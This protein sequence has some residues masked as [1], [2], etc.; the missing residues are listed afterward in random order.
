MLERVGSYY[1]ILPTY[2]QAKKIIWE[3]M[4]ADGFPF[5]AHFPDEIIERKNQAEMS[6]ELINGSRFQLVGS[7]NIDRIVGVNPVGVVFSEY[8]L[9]D[10]RSYELY[11]PILNENGGWALFNGTPRGKNHF[12]KL[13]ERVQDDPT[14]W[15]SILSINDTRRDAPGESG[16]PVVTLEMLEQDR[17]EGA[18]EELI[19]QENYVSFNGRMTGSYY[20]HLI[21]KMHEDKRITDVP[22]NPKRPVFTVWDLG[23]SDAMVV[24]FCQV[25]GQYINV[26]DYLEIRNEG[27]THFA[28]EVKN[29]SYFY[30]NHWA[31]HDI[32][33]RELSTGKSRLEIAQGLG[34]NFR[35]IEKLAIQDGIGALRALF[36]LLRI[37]QTKCERLVDCLT[38]YHKEYDDDKHEFK[39]APVHDWASHGADAARYLALIYDREFDNFFKPIASA[40][41][42]ADVF[43]PEDH[44]PRR[45]RDAGLVEAAADRDDLF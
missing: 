33:Q 32:K 28:K 13:Y 6:V 45:I 31:P 12:Y 2:S 30:S 41:A 4:D 40:G 18:E 39:D 44:D 38:Q 17:K 7:D 34:L 9:Q 37:D 8:S 11:R 20:G 35:L 15:C 3:G 26:I 29:K 27:L 24:L 10:P 36:S 19:Q 14:W 43:E 22:W 25:D 42:Q 16:G 1:Y 23:V 5:M 21:Q